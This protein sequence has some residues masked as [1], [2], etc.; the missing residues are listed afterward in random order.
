MSCFVSG[1]GTVRKKEK[2]NRIYAHV[3]V[4]F[5]VVYVSS[6]NHTRLNEPEAVVVKWS[7]WPVAVS[8][9]LQSQCRPKAP[10]IFFV[11]KG[12]GDDC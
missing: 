1:L 12:G 4:M 5:I 10:Q 6:R 11:W 2:K 9:S 3:R 7:P 8:H